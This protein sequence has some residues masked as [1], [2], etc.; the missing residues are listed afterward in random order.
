MDKEMEVMLQT[1]GWSYVARKGPGG[2]YFQ[3]M[4]AMDDQQT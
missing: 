2:A 3:R 1:L 4:E